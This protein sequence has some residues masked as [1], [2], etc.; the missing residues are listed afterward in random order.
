MTDWM[1]SLFEAAGIPQGWDRGK[2]SEFTQEIVYMLHQLFY[3]EVGRD[4]PLEQP[5][6]Q[7]PREEDRD[8]LQHKHGQDELQA[9]ERRDQASGSKFE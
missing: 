3:S 8:A 1:P 7:S 2:V 6:R 9:K 5:P 4:Q